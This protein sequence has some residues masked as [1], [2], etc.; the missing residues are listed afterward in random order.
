MKTLSIIAL[1]F[2][3][4]SCADK[5]TDKHSSMKGGDQGPPPKEFRDDK[6]TEVNAANSDGAARPI[7][8]GK[9]TTQPDTMWNQSSP[10]ANKPF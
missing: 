2:T 7:A 4:A 9:E 6:P 3:L 5:M 10:A 1:A 8:G